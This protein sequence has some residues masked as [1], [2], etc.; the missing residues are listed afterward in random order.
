MIKDEDS[1]TTGTA[2]GTGGVATA[3]LYNGVSFFE[4]A[5]T[6]KDEPTV[7]TAADELGTVVIDAKVEVSVFGDELDDG[8][9]K[10]VVYHAVRK[11]VKSD[12]I[13]R[14][15]YRLGVRR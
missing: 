3:E 4:S 12:Y 7:I 8:G 15:T 5:T 1:W 14:N 2:V 13:L 10:L 11:P 6:L 9:G